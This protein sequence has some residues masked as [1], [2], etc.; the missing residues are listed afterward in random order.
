MLIIALTIASL[1]LGISSKAQQANSDKI[2]ARKV[3][4]RNP[5]SS[6][7]GDAFVTALL[8]SH[9]PGGALLVESCGE[10]KEQV[11]IPT[12]ATLKDALGLITTADTKYDW[13]SKEKVVNLTPKYFALSPL[14]IR[15][16]EFKVT[17]SSVV[18]AY[19]QLY[20]KPEVKRGIK[21]LGLRSPRFQFIVGGI[22][23][24]QKRITLDYKN[25]TL[26][27]ALNAIVEADGQKIW[28]LSIVMTCD[29][30][31]EYVARLLN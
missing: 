17:N 7:I 10:K 25:I 13:V 2:L 5:Q 3:G 6:Y 12:D 20:D 22:N 28:I 31:S 11:L 16:S 18:D 8:N 1:S 21:D 19:N 30:R 24:N 14:D 15:I 26:G 23:P 29:G 4:V 27:E 9:T